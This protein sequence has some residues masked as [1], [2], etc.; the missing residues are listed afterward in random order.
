MENLPATQRMLW[1]GA[2]LLA[3]WGCPL[4][5]VVVAALLVRLRSPLRTSEDPGAD[6][7]RLAV[8]NERSQAGSSAPGTYRKEERERP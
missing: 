6:A 8:P 2:G 3:K 1:P 7:S 4:R 5:W